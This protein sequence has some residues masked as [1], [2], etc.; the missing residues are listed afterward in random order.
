[1]AQDNKFQ[2]IFIMNELE[3]IM[4]KNAAICNLLHGVV[5][6]IT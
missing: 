2:E 5:F 6:P 1:M 3:R 4:V